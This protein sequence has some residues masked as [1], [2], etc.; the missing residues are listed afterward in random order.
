MCQNFPISRRDFLAGTGAMLLA[1]HIPLLAESAD[2][3]IIDIHQHTDYAGRTHEHL[4]AHQRRMGISKTIL[5]PAGTPAFGMSTHQGK[6]NGLQAKCS[7]NYVCYAI[8]Q[9]YPGEFTFGANEVPDLPDAVKEIEKYLKLGAPMIGEL[10]FGLDC[11]SKEMQNIYK[12]AEEYKV[13]VLMHWQF[14]MFNYNFERFPKMLEKYPKVN[15]IG[16]AQTWWA[17]IDKNHTD[18]NVLYPKTKVTK[19]GLTDRLLSDYANMY[20]DLSAGSGL[21]SMTRDEDHATDF[22]TR[23][24]DKLLYGSDCDDIAG[25]G[26]ACQGSQTISEIK[27]LASSKKVERK[28]LYENAK[29]LFR[30]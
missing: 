4:L 23:H 19:G 7:G 9:K 2:E 20:G 15:F 30:L 11:D 27:K 12:L 17:N 16:H 14:Q 5:L 3:P 22:L 1:S 26:K 21:L 13:P 18:Q 25:S 6:T 10:K 28:L 8:S 29:Q 24:Q